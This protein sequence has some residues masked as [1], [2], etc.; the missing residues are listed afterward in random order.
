M[1]MVYILLNN[2]HGTDLYIS[3]RTGEAG[4]Y[5]NCVSTCILNHDSPEFTDDSLMSIMNDHPVKF[6]VISSPLDLIGF[7]RFTEKFPN[8]K[9][10]YIL[11]DDNDI[12]LINALKY[13]K[14]FWDI[15]EFGQEDLF[16]RYYQQIKHTLNQ[17]V[18]H[19][20]DLSVEN[21]RKVL[22]EFEIKNEYNVKFNRI[23]NKKHWPSFLETV[24]PQYQDRITGIE[25]KEITTN[26]EL[27][28]NYLESF[29]N[30]EI[31]YNILR[32][33]DRY[34]RM[35]HLPPKLLEVVNG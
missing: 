30:K 16:F 13:Y 19:I 18:A 4:G 33:Y 32:Y 27:V 7:D 34:V 12:L 5:R 25:F 8:W 11:Y 29:T 24:P 28:M 35:Q 23:A 20:R 6:I 31:T 1:T 17:D 2:Y 3:D 14:S 10:T 22:M 15:N 9:A 21:I 26:K